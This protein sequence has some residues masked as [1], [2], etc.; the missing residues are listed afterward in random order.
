MSLGSIDLSTSSKLMALVWNPNMT[1]ITIEVA[2]EFDW[3]LSI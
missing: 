2:L 1:M 3:Y